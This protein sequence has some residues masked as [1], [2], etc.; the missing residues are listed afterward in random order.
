MTRFSRTITQPTRRF[1]QL[2]RCAARSASCMKYWSQLGRR[3]ASLGRF[4][5]VSAEWRD[6]I[7]VVE[8]SSLSWARSNRTWRPVP[9][10]NRCASLR[11]TKASREGGVSWLAAHLGPSVVVKM[12]GGRVLCTGP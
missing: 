8:F 4:S 1:M 2:L 3:R 11:R 10:A 7:E 6:G 12:R 9:A 5:D